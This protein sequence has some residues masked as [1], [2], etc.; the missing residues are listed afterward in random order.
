VLDL[1]WS[2]VEVRLLRQADAVGTLS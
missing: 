2:A 1:A